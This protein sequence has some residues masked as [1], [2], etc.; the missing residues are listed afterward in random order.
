[1]QESV[2]LQNHGPVAVLEFSNPP[3]NLLTMRL[4]DTLRRTVLEIGADRSVRAVVL[5]STGDRSF[6]A[7][8]DIREFPASR[9]QG[10]SRAL[11]EHAC[12]DAVERTAP[13]VIAAVQGHVLGG[14]LELAMS[15]DLRVGSE[16]ATLGLT[17]IRLGVFPSGGGSQRLAVLVGTSRAKRLMLLG[18]VIGAEEALRIGLLDE[19]VPDGT[20]REAAM[21]LAHRIAAQPRLATQAI[22]R[23]VDHGRAFGAAAGQAMEVR[24]IS[25]LFTSHDAREGVQAFLDS[26]TPNFTHQASEGES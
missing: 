5:C 15:A 20:V 24:L 26:R 25:E 17:E 13:P 16:S 8:S 4:R 23:A 1:M 19:V 6:S 3:L 22:K 21:A 10:E 7:G 12:Y 18:E 2:S 9:E 11:Q 14:G